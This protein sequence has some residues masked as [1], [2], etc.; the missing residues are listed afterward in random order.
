M[1]GGQGG[2]TGGELAVS[3]DNPSTMKSGRDYGS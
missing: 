1:N 3:Y 2:Y